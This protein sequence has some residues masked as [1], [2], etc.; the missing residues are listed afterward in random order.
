MATTAHA[1][2]MYWAEQGPD[3]ISRANIDGTGVE[4]LV[5]GLSFPV[6]IALDGA[7]GKMYWVDSELGNIQRAN[8]DGSSV[9]EL[10]TG[11]GTARG[12][13]LD[14]AGGKIYWVD[15]GGGGKIQRA[16]LDGSG[17]EDLI[18]SLG[19]AWGMALDVDGGKMYWI[20]YLADKIQR[21][22]LDGS[23]VEELVS[24]LSSPRGIALDV[25]SGKMYWTDLSPGKVQRAN[26]EIPDGETAGT[27]T[28]IE[29]LV[30]GLTG[31]MGIALD[32]TIDNKMYWT[33]YI[34][35]GTSKIQRA[36]LD[37]S[38]VEDLVTGLDAPQGIAI[39]NE[40]KI[41]VDDDASGDPG[42]G[43]PTISDPC[44]DGSREYPFDAIQE[45]IDAAVDGNTVV[46]LQGTYTGPNNVDLDFGG[47]AITVRSIDPNDPNVVAA[48][49]IDCNGTEAD[50]HRGFDFHNNED[51][52]S[53]VA[54]FTIINGDAN[55]GGSVYCYGSSPS[56]FN[57]IISGNTAQFEGGG[58]YC[59]YYSSPTITNCT[60]IG[61]TVD[62][63]G[64][65]IYCRWN[66]NPMISNCLISGNTADMYGGGIHCLYSSSPRI[67]NCTIGGNLAYDKGGGI[68]C[69][70]DTS[71]PTINNSIVS[72]NIATI[73]GGG[74]YCNAGSPTI[75]DCVISGNTAT[76]GGGICCDDNSEPTINVCTIRNN[77]A[78]N[79]G[80]GIFCFD[81]SNL[82]IINSCVNYN[83]ANTG[84]GITCFYNG[85]SLTLSNCTI[86]GNTAKYH[87]GGIY[88]SDVSNPT[89]SNCTISGNVAR[90]Y[91]GGIYCTLNSDLGITNSIL[92]RNAAGLKGMQVYLGS[93][94]TML[95]LSFSDVQGGEDAVNIDTGSTLNWG[96]GNI[97]TAPL[98]TP[99]GHLTW[100]SPGIDAGDSNAVGP[101]T[102][103][104]DGDGNTIEPI[105]LD[106][107][108]DPRFV[109]D[110]CI[111]DTGNGPAPIVDMGADEFLDTDG[112]GLPDWWEQKYFG[113][114][115]SAEPNA[116]PDGDWLTN[117]EE[118][119]LYSS[120][121]NV[122]PYYVDVNNIA[123]P[124][125][126]GSLANPFDTIAEGIN[127]ASDGDTV[128]VAAG[129]Y[130]G[131]NNIDID[132]SGKL[133]VLY[134]PNGPS[135]TIIDCNGLGRGFDFHSGETAAAAV[136]GFTITGGQAD[137]GG[138]IRCDRSYP[139]FR[140]CIIT[141]NSDPN[142]GTAGIYC[143]LSYPTLA[144][145]NIVDN[146]GD[147]L[148]MEY[149]GARIEGVVELAGNDWVGNDLMLYG[150]GTI[151][152]ESDV[153]LYLHDSW[154]RCNIS[155]P[156]T[157]QVD[158][159]SELIIEKNAV[160]DLAHETD[161]NFNGRI[162]CDGL[163][164]L[165]DE[166]TITD[167]QVYV[168]RASFEDDVIILN[169]VVSA[170]AGAPYGQFYIEG[171]VEIWLD[172]I[173]ADGD[174]YLDFDPTEFDVNNIYIGTIDVNITEGVD[175]AQGGLFEL[176]G[177][178]NLVNIIDCCEPNSPFFC[179]AEYIPPFD[180]NNWTINRLELVEDAKLNLTNRFDFQYPYDDGGDDE[181]LHVN[182]LILGANSVLNTA[183]N[184]LYYETIDRDPTARVINVPL[185][186][187][188][189]VNI[190]F[191]DE[192]DY[193]TRVKHNNFEHPTNPAY[194]RDHVTRIEGNEPDPHGMMQMINLEDIEPGSPTEGNEFNARAKAFFAK[195]SEERVLITF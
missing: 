77:E 189:L 112:D 18:T 43:D 137:Y 22:N 25:A 131:P 147:G 166:V 81:G 46:V 47:K 76:E 6:G 157:I 116:N 58:I 132:F 4:E 152:I 101:D 153:T 127:A 180:T 134:A 65:G 53:M 115:N 136:V 117:L 161:P 182:D 185:L 138:A 68:S 139:Q 176:R 159:E 142:E 104:L 74:L 59:L 75:N 61:N 145:C 119:E 17:V 193:L 10:V 170:E 26:M 50:P 13:D 164:R 12:I 92:W 89:I 155:G 3:S 48:T 20:M 107:D 146:I 120:D 181:V 97:D 124:C 94:S 121:P 36:N 184:Y 7:G 79:S 163:L 16:N 123:D 14:A 84:A 178:P 167:A 111:P 109:D 133:V 32:L 69:L 86:M 173:W 29:D 140:D 73:Y 160:I 56:I 154:I 37:G 171:N 15:G 141:G 52:H 19:S 21:A 148:R 122:T 87:G 162:F 113:D 192:N 2:K 174:R 38:G 187:F 23:G 102:T 67:D 93:L 151:K 64:G 149:G 39:N 126:D 103:D 28:D 31:P 114:V 78:N 90:W 110:P 128:L 60:I 44:E 62:R 158:L 24:G 11:L 99:D 96:V 186:G 118:Y 9:E 156:G 165:R 85:S 105:P 129:T 88:C 106:I 144:D 51:E 95:T 72:D 172:R 82:S 42:P 35:V 191:D 108:D 98:L 130:T 27:R 5:T 168:S 33:H 34:S 125:E 30:T 66:S 71:N 177:E 143:Y 49:I 40:E 188:S 8:L 150:N 55:E 91:G 83:I 183:F 190:S 1:Q 194:D 175:G 135:V 179:Q 80:G 70:G 45:G 100:A 63:F 169:S 41:F 54:G 57:C 195:S